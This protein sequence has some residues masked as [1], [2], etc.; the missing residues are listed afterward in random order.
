MKSEKQ[1]ETLEKIRV[2]L[3]EIRSSLKTIQTY[4]GYM[5][6]MSP[7]STWANPSFIEDIAT[8]SH[9]EVV[10]LSRRIDD[11]LLELDVLDADKSS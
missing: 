6:Y 10:R 5:Q 8:R 2:L 3:Q 1:L 7:E 4:K 11:I 9:P